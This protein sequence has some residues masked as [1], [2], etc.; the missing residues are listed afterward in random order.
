MPVYRIN[1]FDNGTFLYSTEAK[2]KPVVGQSMRGA[3]RRP[4]RII[5]IEEHENNVID[6]ELIEDERD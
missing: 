2:S 3:T 6:V 5:E 1:V 4:M